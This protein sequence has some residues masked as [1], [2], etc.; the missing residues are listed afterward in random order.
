MSFSRKYE[1]SFN[2]IENT[3]IDLNI[4]KKKI[5]LQLDSKVFLPHPDSLLLANSI[6]INKGEMICDLGL[7]TG[8]LAITAAKLGASN[9]FGSDINNKA[10]KNSKKN[11]IL[12]DVKKKCFFKKGK[13]FKPFGEKLFDVILT[14]PPQT[15]GK[16]ISEHKYFKQATEAGN[17]GT[18]HTLLLL[19][20]AKKHLKKKGRLYLVLK[21]W[22]DWK[23]V[24]KEMKKDYKCKKIGETFSPAWTRDEHRLKQI[25]YLVKQGKAKFMMKNG[26]KYYKIYAY[27]CT[28]LT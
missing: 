8:I 10:I 6:K 19:K 16:G 14:N 15:P 3:L 2:L 24:I 9:V 12:N 5:K 23:K 26:K 13:W 22:M 25:D 20:K 11:S 1:K 21:E 28:L 17:D 27:E 18:K 7:G 4:Q